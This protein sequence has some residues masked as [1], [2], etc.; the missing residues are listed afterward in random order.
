VHVSAARADVDDVT[1]AGFEHLG[2]DEAAEVDRRGGGC[3]CC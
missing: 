1:A 3:C 2:Q